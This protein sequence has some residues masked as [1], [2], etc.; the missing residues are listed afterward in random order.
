MTPNRPIP[1][2]GNRHPVHVLLDLFSD[3]NNRLIASGIFSSILFFLF[4]ALASSNTLSRVNAVINHNQD[5]VRNYQ[6]IKNQSL[7]FVAKLDSLKDMKHDSIWS[8]S[9]HMWKDSALFYK[10]DRNKLEASIE[11]MRSKVGQQ[12]DNIL[13]LE[14]ELRQKDLN[15]RKERSQ[16]NFDE[17]IYDELGKLN[18]SLLIENQNLKMQLKL[19]QQRLTT[20]ANK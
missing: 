14:N 10:K 12:R 13:L 11:D 3:T 1:N 15:M 20:Q 8:D 9:L 5:V 18:D 6:D 7:V 2:D 19:L 17:G 4:A 16:S